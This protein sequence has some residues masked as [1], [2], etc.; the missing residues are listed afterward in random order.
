MSTTDKL[1]SI[2]LLVLVVGIIGTMFSEAVLPHLSAMTHA[3][4]PR[5]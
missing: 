5:P 1:V 4:S 2:A 3:L